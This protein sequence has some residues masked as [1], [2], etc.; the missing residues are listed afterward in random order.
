[1]VSWE[2]QLSTRAVGRAGGF[3]LFQARP[4]KDYRAGEP[5]V[6]AA[7]SPGRAVGAQGK[8]KGRARLG[9]QKGGTLFSAA[10]PLGSLVRDRSNPSE[11]SWT[12]STSCLLRTPVPQ[13]S[14]DFIF[15]GFYGALRGFAFAGMRAGLA[16][17]EGFPRSSETARARRTGR[18][19]PVTISPPHGPPRTAE[20]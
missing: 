9:K 10:S 1:M 20:R 18:Q 19:F 6:T 3:F 16:N 2:R 8:R 13:K 7:D 12:V 17:L 14:C 11:E 5:G 15:L 4:G